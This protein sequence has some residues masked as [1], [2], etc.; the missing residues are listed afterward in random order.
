MNNLSQKELDL[1]SNKILEDYDNK[2]PSIIFKD[3]IKITNQDALIIQSNVAKL[4]EKREEEIIGYKIGCVS[5]DTQKKMGFTQPASG[6]L[7]KSELHNSGVILNKKDYTNPAMEAEFG[8]ILNRD[9]KPELASFDYILE[10]IEGIY[11]VIEIHNLVF[12]GNEPYGAELLANNAI[13]AGIVIGPETKLPSEKV[14][15]DLKLIYDKE[16]I[17]TWT[18]KIW[19]NDMLSELNWLIKE[20]AKKNNYLKKGDLILTGAYGFPVPINEKKLVE[21]TSS[22]FGNVKAIFD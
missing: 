3:K 5:K 20:Q 11:T 19:P 15:T 17:D 13:H 18:N 10:S 2:N 8:I 4:R 1:L 16:V 14:E 21:V 22:A 9:L 7:W 12:Y 6:Y